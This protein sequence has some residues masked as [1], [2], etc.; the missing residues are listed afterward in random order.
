M[1]ICMERH[2]SDLSEY[3]GFHTSFSTTNLV[4]LA[5]PQYEHPYVLLQ[6]VF[7][8]PL[9]SLCGTEGPFDPII[10]QT[11]VQREQNNHLTTLK[12]V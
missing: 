6:M 8:Y 7:I 12:D 5:E 3:I 11:V 9:D 4:V 1:S 10:K 2:V